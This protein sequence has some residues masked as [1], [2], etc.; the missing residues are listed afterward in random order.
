MNNNLLIVGAGMYGVVAKEIAE[1]TNRFQKIDFVDDGLTQAYNGDRVVGTTADIQ[2]LSQEYNCVIV[3]I[4][5]PQIRLSLL[6][7]LEKEGEFNV[8]SLIS[9]RSFVSPSAS[10]GKGVFV[11]PMAVVHA[12]CKVENG[13]IVS[14]GAVVNHYST[15]REG[16][17]VDCNATV[18]GNKT[19]SAKTKV[20]SGKVFE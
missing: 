14:A 13:C 2:K 12:G 1:E 10:L 16:V 5:N 8:V 7:R 15:L 19:V 6:E 9:P 11:E 18:L 3:A 17:H 20:Y 4:G